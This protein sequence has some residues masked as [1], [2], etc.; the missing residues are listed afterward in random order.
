MPATLAK[1]KVHYR[2]ATTT[3]RCGNCT[4]FRRKKTGGE[5]TLVMGR[6]E[7]YYGCDSVGAKMNGTVLPA[8]KPTVA[9]LTAPKCASCV[10]AQQFSQGMADCHGLPP[11]I[12]NLGQTKDFIGRQGFHIEAFVPKVSQDRPACS[13]HKPKLDFATSGNS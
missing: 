13:L 10:Y 7:S 2:P 6:I 11:V 8:F 9:T 12:V 3:K 5:C 1:S 4:M